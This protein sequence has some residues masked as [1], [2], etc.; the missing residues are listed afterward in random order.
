MTALYID[1]DACPV[2]AEAERVATRHKVRMFVV[3][4]GGLRPSQNPL[5]E[6]VIVP[7]GPD[8]ADMWIADRAG[9]GDVV[10]TSDIPLAAKCVEAGAKV[11]KHNGEALTAA[12]IGNVLATRDLMADLR[13]ADPF[14]QGGGKGFTKADRSRFLDALERELRAAARL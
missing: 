2:K 12:N 13:A 10:V 14:R 4:N 5:V 11:L 6:T 1:A 9:I 8:V 3:S 7:D